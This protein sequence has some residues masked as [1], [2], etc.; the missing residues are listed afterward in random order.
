MII[1]IVQRQL[2][3]FL[4]VFTCWY[5]DHN[6]EGVLLMRNILRR[7]GQWLWLR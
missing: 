6:L 3:S 4:S 1:I 5:C 2:L 7:V